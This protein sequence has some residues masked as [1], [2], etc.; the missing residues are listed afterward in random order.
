MGN[1]RDGMVS[2]ITFK[3]FQ[4]LFEHDNA[5]QYIETGAHYELTLNQFEPEAY[6]R[7]CEHGKYE[8]YFIRY[9]A[10]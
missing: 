8:K 1:W 4:N 3:E 5:I 7:Y 6:M 9:G 10:E 2:E